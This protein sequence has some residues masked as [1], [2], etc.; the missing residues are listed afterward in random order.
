MALNTPSDDLRVAMEIDNQRPAVSRGNVPG[1]DL[2]AV[3]GRENQ[4]FGLGQTGCGWGDAGI[5]RMIE[6]RALTEIKSPDGGR[7]AKNDCD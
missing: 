7:I 3:V 6:Q 4:L 2:L 5:V 1:N